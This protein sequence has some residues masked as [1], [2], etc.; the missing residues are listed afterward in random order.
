[1]VKLIETEYDRGEGG[2]INGTAKDN[3]HTYDEGEA[4]R[5]DESE[6]LSQSLT[7]RKLFLTPKKEEQSQ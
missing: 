2:G 7:A 3:V 1:M 6:L 4:I 5:P